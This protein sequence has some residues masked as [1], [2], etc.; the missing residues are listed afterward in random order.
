MIDRQLMRDV[1]LAVLLGLPTAALSRPQPPAAEATPRATPVV[2]QAALADQS[3][4]ERRFNIES[5]L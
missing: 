4:T 1:A 3:S 2:E 5:E